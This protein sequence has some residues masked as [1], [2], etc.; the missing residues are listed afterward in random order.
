MAENLRDSSW[1]AY[2]YYQNGSTYREKGRF[3]RS[4][5]SLKKALQYFES[6]KDTSLISTLHN[7]I[8]YTFNL[9]GLPGIPNSINNHDR[10]V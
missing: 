9:R 7:D 10:K 1:I 8:G 2:G 5:N 4:L 6:L 3:D